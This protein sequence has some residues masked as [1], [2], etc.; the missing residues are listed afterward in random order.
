VQL[1]KDLGADIVIDY[2][3]TD[4]CSELSTSGP[5]DMVLDNVG[6]PTD[7][8]WK[9]PGFTKP[10]ARYVQIGSEVSLGFV[11]DVAF[12]FLLPTWLGGGQRP[13]SFGLTSTSF[14]HLSKLGQLVAEK[15]VVPV[16]DET[17]DFNNVPQAYNKLKTGRARGK[18]VVRVASV[19]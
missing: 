11:Y 6:A 3:T 17:F 8:Y 2:R 7:L 13:F 9:S 4:V 5:Y 18:I 12:R 15:S 16:I 19:D 10:G 1:C 14:E